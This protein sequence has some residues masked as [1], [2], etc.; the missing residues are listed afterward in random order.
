MLD[1]RES[2]DSHAR[3]EQ[4]Q[5]E[6]L[7][8]RLGRWLYALSGRG[9]PWCSRFDRD[10]RGTFTTSSLRLLA[11][12]HIRVALSSTQR[13][14]MATCLGFVSRYCY[15]FYAESGEEAQSHFFVKHQEQ[16][17]KMVCRR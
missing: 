9:I 1:K 12:S 13:L 8:D 14:N 16:V 6:K 15:R 17:G 4:S 5:V 7:S 3:G 11:T 10:D 2:I